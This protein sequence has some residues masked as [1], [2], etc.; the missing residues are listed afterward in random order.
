[1]CTQAENFND[2]DNATKDGHSDS[3]MVGLRIDVFQ[4]VKAMKE[5]TVDFEVS[6]I[7]GTETKIVKQVSSWRQAGITWVRVGPRAAAL[8]PN[9]SD[10]LSW[11]HAK[12]RSLAD[13]TAIYLVLNRLDIPYDIEELVEGIS[14]ET[15]V[16]N[17]NNAV[18]N[19]A[20]RNLP[21]LGEPEFVWTVLYQSMTQK[22]VK[23]G[24]YVIKVECVKTR[25][26]FIERDTV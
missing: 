13:G 2:D 20:D 9:T 3:V 1:M 19:S 5:R 8:T 10:E 17:L 6:T 7:I 11:D 23:L 24:D 26:E 14:H 4:D 18:M 16:E 15:G 22:S 25:C 21:S 12:A